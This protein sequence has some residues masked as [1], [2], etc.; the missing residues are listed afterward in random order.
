MK[1]SYCAK[2]KKIHSVVK[3]SLTLLHWENGTPPREENQF[4]ILI[5][6]SHVIYSYSHWLLHEKKKSPAIHWNTGPDSA[7][8]KGNEN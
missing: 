2:G 7:H 1:L 4:C 8:T 6:V 5:P 3:E